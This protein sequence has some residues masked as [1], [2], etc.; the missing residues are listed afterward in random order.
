MPEGTLGPDVLAYAHE[1][2]EKWIIRLIDGLF[3]G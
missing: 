3:E 2:G 1:N